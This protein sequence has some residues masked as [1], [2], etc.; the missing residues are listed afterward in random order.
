[1]ER[2]C[3]ILSIALLLLAHMAAAQTVVTQITVTPISARV[4]QLDWTIPS[5]THPLELYRGISGGDLEYVRQ[6]DTYNTRRIYDTLP[7]ML[8][9][10]SVEYQLVDNIVTQS[11]VSNRQTVLVFDPVPTT[12]CQ[13]LVATVDE[14][15]QNIVL[16]WE[17][18]P[19]TDIMGYYLCRGTPCLDYDTVWGRT[20]TTYTCIDL[21]PSEPYTFRLLAFDSCMN[22]SPLTEYFT[23]LVLRVATEDCSDR[24]SLRWNA[25]EGLP[26]GVG[27]YVVQVRYGTSA[28]W[29]EVLACHDLSAEIEVPSYVNHVE[30]RL[31]AQNPDHTLKAYSNI[32]AHD[33]ATSDSA[34][35]L[36]ISHASMSADGK[37][38]QLALYVDADFP[39][40]EYAIYRAVGNGPF[41]HY[42]D[43]PYTGQSHLIYTDY[44]ISSTAEVYR[45]KISALDGCGRN[46]KFSNIAATMPI[47]LTDEGPAVSLRWNPYIG[48]DG[49]QSYVI[50]RRSQ[51]ES[52]WT[53]ISTTANC[54]YADNIAAF[55][56]LREGLYY[57]VMAQESASHAFGFSDTA[58]TAQV[59]YKRD[60][61]MYFP[62]AFT[63][64]RSDNNT[65]GPYYTFI[66][67][68]RYEFYIYSRQGI[69]LFSSTDPAVRWDGTY[70]GSPVPQG[71]YVYTARVHFLNNLF[72]QYTGTVVLLR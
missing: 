34:A 21:S 2:W 69:L 6:I 13:Q 42:A 24:L 68:S 26:G 22:Q 17:M 48:W 3:R 72:K 19:D 32:V 16:S 38:V 53:P 44:R 49:Q 10:D 52:V 59:L 15:S 54:E 45:Y 63:P 70:Q 11:H 28:S 39:T 33:Y 29:T 7:H 18:N 20:N 60:G 5:Y 46:E 67:D 50:L 35:F 51:S 47:A 23:N 40:T 9:G 58:H 61:T 25:Y 71:A 62:N 31:A 36:Y 43:L 12:P 8:C 30:V 55:P 4:C 14:I 65:F 66:D 1:M 27:E 37:S 64:D 41:E 56:D 57:R